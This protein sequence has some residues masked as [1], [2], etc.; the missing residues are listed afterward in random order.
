MDAGPVA[1]L[2]TE[3]GE[4]E[5]ALQPAGLDMVAAYWCSD[6]GRHRR[7]VVA[8]TSTELLLRLRAIR[9]EGARGRSDLAFTDAKASRK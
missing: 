8:A 5:V 1:L 7:C 6:D 3:F 4:W 2:A 9:R